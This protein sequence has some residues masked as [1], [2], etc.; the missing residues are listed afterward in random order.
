MIWRWKNFYLMIWWPIFTLMFDQWSQLM[1]IRIT[2]NVFKLIKLNL[3][4]SNWVSTKLNWIYIHKYLIR[5]IDAVFQLRDDVNQVNQAFGLLTTES[6]STL[7]WCN[8]MHFALVLLQAVG[9]WISHW[10][11]LVYWFATKL[12]PVKV[13]LT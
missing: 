6:P 9:T 11:W 3:N 12:M 7:L 2:T 4:W 13:I 10:Q 1:M 5:R 8:V